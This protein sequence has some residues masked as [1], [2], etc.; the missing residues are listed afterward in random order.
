[1]VTLTPNKM[2]RYSE[3]TLD[4]T[5]VRALTQEKLQHIYLW[6]SQWGVKR[7]ART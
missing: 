1:M 3:R 6:S 7:G 2:V 4:A 5:G